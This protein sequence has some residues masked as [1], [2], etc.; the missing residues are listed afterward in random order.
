M[1]E[2]EYVCNRC[3]SNRVMNDAWVPANDPEDVRVFDAA[4]CEDCDGEC[5]IEVAEVK[6]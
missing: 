5:T 1:N 6:E 4:F 2:K 3:G